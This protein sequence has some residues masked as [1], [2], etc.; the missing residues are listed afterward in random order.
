MSEHIHYKAQGTNSPRPKACIKRHT[1]R[2]K[3]RKTEMGEQD[4]N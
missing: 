1:K 2:R 3:E 4:E